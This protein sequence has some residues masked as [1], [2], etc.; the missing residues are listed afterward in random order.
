MSIEE[1]KEQGTEKPG[2]PELSPEQVEAI[3]QRI[4]KQK[5]HAG[6]ASWFYWIAGLSLVT[7]VISLSGGSW[8]FSW[9][10]LA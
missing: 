8:S 3:H 1:I 9:P 2:E 6:G 4:L 5:A 10:A 7:S